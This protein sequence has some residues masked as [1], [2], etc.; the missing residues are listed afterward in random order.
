MAHLYTE[1]YYPN[2]TGFSC[3]GRWDLWARD[4]TVYQAIA[5]KNYETYCLIFL[6]GGSLRVLNRLL[7]TWDGRTPRGSTVT[8]FYCKAVAEKNQKIKTGHSV[9]FQR[10]AAERFGHVSYGIRCTKVQG[11]DSLRFCAFYNRS[12]K[13]HRW[14]HCF[15]KE[16]HRRVW[17]LHLAS[18]LVILLKQDP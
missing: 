15:Q 1:W 13:F 3:V 17:R 5:C 9:R 10:Q 4:R 16:F 12:F 6:K 11:E 7:L 14:V 2:C 8:I 18:K